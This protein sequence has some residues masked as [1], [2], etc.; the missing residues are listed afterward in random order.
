M[1]GN[2]PSG[3]TEQKQTK[4]AWTHELYSSK[5]RSRHILTIC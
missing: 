1:N 5:A 4:T 3:E 2:V